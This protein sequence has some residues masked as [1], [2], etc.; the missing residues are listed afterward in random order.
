MEN[1]KTK[2]EIKKEFKLL[3]DVYSDHIVTSLSEG[4]SPIKAMDR[5]LL[6]VDSYKKKLEV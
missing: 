4:K 1:I 5:I 3:F 2:K 6:L